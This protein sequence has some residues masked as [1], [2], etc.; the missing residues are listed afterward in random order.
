MID[1]L[2][3]KRKVIQLR[4]TIREHWAE[5]RNEMWRTMGGQD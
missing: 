5:K 1:Y 2:T 3:N 4:K